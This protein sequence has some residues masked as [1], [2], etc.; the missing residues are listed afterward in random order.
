ME[1][2]AS[3][4]LQNEASDGSRWRRALKWLG[5]AAVSL[6][7]LAWLIWHTEWTPLLQALS[8]VQLSWC[9]AALVVFLA[10]QLVSSYRWQILSRGLGFQESIGRFYALYLVGMFFNL[11]LPTSMGG[12]VV[13]AWYL[14][15]GKGRRWRAMVSVF[16]ERFSGLLAL[17]VIA[18]VATLP[19]WD[20]LPV[21]AILSA[22]GCLAGALIGML[23]LPLLALHM[24]RLQLLAEGVAFSRGHVQ[25][26]LAAFAI[27]LVV[28]VAG[29][30]Q[31][32]MLGVAIGLSAPF[33]AYAVAVP[34]VSLL[35]MLPISVNGV[36]VREGSLV[37]LLGTAGVASAE[38]VALGLL[39]FFVQAAVSLL[40]GGVYLVGQFG[41]SHRKDAHESLRGH[42]DQGRAGQSARAA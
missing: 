1:T 8:R 34:L 19:T 11:F 4:A 29:I 33:E 38:A 13:K 37:L 6:G 35:T 23:V 30:V 42:P 17:L 18:A 32:G 40:G 36:G 14:A 39:W 3:A 12:D 15:G 26:G 16:S 24:P 20:I 5:R 21:W 25:R 10:A 28:Q 31:V 27:S 7:V 41:H 9:V 2:P 22:W